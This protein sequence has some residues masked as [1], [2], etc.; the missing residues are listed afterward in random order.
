M[1]QLHVFK[2]ANLALGLQLQKQLAP[3]GGWKSAFSFY[4]VGRK[5]QFRRINS[6]WQF[7]EHFSLT[8][9][10]ACMFT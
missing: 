6:G 9:V 5:G 8:L 7:K 2:Q 10:V 4:L 3:Q 1:I